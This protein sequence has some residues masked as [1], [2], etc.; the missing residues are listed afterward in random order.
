MTVKDGLSGNMFEIRAKFVVNT[1]GPWLDRMLSLL[2]G[3]R[4]SRKLVFSK[5]FNLLVRRQIVP[6][7]AVGLYSRACIN[8]RVCMRS[9]GGLC[10]LANGH[11][12]RIIHGGLRYLQYGDIRRVRRSIAERTAFMRIAPHLVHPPPMTSRSYS[13]RFVRPLGWHLM[14]TAIK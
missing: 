9:E 11:T 4:P 10:A 6:D 3:H 2:N 12:L 1:S 13:R 5:A 14:A 7:Y 8:D